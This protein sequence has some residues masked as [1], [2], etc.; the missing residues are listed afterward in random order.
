MVAVIIV[1][2]L[3]LVL[4]YFKQP[5]V[6]GI[7]LVIAG[8]IAFVSILSGDAALHANP[9][10]LASLSPDQEEII[11]ENAGTFDAT[12]I[13]V[14]TAQADGPWEIESLSPDTSYNIKLHRMV[15]KIT[16]SV[17]YL[18]KAGQEKIKVFKLGGE[19]VGEEDPLKPA[20]PLFSWKEK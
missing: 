1:I 13:R 4:F 7:L 10:I 6:A 9:L 5:Y 3:S 18:N 12:N 8:T 20:F 14:K 19:P 15:D 17:S 11:I 2:G 16:I